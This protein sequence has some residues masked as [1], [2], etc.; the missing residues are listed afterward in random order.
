METPSCLWSQVVVTYLDSLFLPLPDHVT[1]NIP[2]SGNS[3]VCHVADT[4]LGSIQENGCKCW[5]HIWAAIWNQ[6]SVYLK[7]VSEQAYISLITPQFN[8]FE[9]HNSKFSW[10]LTS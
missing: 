1:V 9:V 3:S 4:D 2:V 7:S 5:S 6:L 10:A 8:L